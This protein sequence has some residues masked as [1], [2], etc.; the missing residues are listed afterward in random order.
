[1]AEIRTAGLHF[2]PDQH[3]NDMLKSF[4][5]FIQEF[6]LRYDATFPDPYS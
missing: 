6:E 1:M 5:K 4:Y 3:P 2:D